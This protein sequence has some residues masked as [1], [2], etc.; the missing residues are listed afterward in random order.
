MNILPPR[1]KK[2]TI[3]VDSFGLLLSVS[4]IVAIAFIL[5]LVW[6]NNFQYSNENCPDSEEASKLAVA[7]SKD[8][9]TLMTIRHSLSSRYRIR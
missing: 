8:Q 3:K 6:S 5:I 9:V 4:L 2:N 7:C 1:F